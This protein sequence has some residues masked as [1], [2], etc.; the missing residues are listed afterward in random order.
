VQRTSLRSPLT[1]RLAAPQ[2]C[3]SRL[4]HLRVW[5]T[6]C[7]CPRPQ[8]NPRCIHWLTLLPFAGFG[9]S[10]LAVQTTSH[11]TAQAQSVRDPRLRQSLPEPPRI[12]SSRAASSSPTWLG[13]GHASSVV[14]DVPR[15][16][17]S[18]LA[19]ARLSSAVPSHRGSRNARLQGS[20]PLGRVH[21]V[22]ISHEHH[23]SSRGRA[24]GTA[25][26]WRSCS[27]HGHS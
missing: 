27:V 15:F 12:T 26:L 22:T 11:S 1:L 2:R 17:A 10:T 24:T 6:S 14:A 5:A 25:A 19:S 7:A 9:V 20:A 3:P 23:R 21:V 18:P 16:H 4:P 13:L 8:P